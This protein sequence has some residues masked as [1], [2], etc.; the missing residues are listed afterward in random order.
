MELIAV[1]IMI[2]GGIAMAVF[3]LV[4]L[5]I[6]KGEGGGSSRIAA[7]AGSERDRIAASILVQILL[8]GGTSTDDAFREV[9]RRAG[10]AAPVTAGI[11]VANWGETFAGIATEAQRGWLLE[12]AVQP[13]AGRAT[14]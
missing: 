6:A 1:I 14:P 2:A 5:A 11:D 4:A 10:L 8:L 3:V 13:L 7:A 12:T 9:R